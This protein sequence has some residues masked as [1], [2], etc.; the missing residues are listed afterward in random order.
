MTNVEKLQICKGVFQKCYELYKDKI[1]LGKISPH[2]ILYDDKL[3]K[4]ENIDTDLIYLCNLIDIY[5]LENKDI[6][7][8]WMKNQDFI[9]GPKKAKEMKGIQLYHEFTP[10][11]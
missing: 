1:I 2:M 9:F 8:D 7:V 5:N 11:S 4:R 10:Y 6:K 3:E